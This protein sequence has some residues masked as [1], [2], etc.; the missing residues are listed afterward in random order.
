MARYSEH[1]RSLIDQAVTEWSTR[2]LVGDGSLLFPEQLDVW[3]E[4]SAADLYQRFNMSGLTDKRTFM[5]KWAAQLDGASRQVRLFAAELLLVHFLFASSVSGQAKRAIVQETL[6]GSDFALDQDSVGIRALGQA[7]GHPGIGFNVGRDRQ[8]A[9]LIDFTRRLKLRPPEERAEILRDPWRL[10]DFA[11][12]T[13][14]SVREMRHILLHL[15]RPDEFERISSGTHKREIAAAF[16][17]LLGED[18]PQ[19]LDERLLAIRRRLDELMPAGNTQKGLIDFYHPP[20]WGV[21]ES[22]GG[23]DDDGTGDLEALLWKKQIVLY[24]PPGTSKSYQARRLAETLIRRVALDRWKPEGFFTHQQ[25][26]EDVIDRCVRWIQLH[27]GY[28][29][30]EFIRGLRLDGSETRYQPGALPALIDDMAQQRPPDGLP[31][32]PFV[33]VLDEINR[34]DLSALFGEAFSLIERDRRG[35]PGAE[36]PGLNVGDPPARLVVPEDLYIIGTMNEID[37]SVETLDF[38]LRRRFLWRECP[39]ERDTLL[40]IISSRWHDDVGKKWHHE[41]AMP[42]L[43][44]FADRAAALN[45]AIDDSEELGRAYA[46]GHTYFADLTFFLGTWLAGRKSAPPNG[47]F[48]WTGRNRAQPPLVDLWERSLRP[49]LEQYLAGSDAGADE[50]RRLRSIFFDTDGRTG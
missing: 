13:D 43:E 33:L 50:L 41:S 8:V 42:Q 16:S 39:F 34:T 47:T 30:E 15:L 37:Q 6:A 4:Q 23:G 45:D 32:L 1:D 19:D 44:R 46:I 49:L 2:C 18:A 25:A 28:G 22:A 36:L 17:G 48:L 29:Y 38:A 40:S 3:T 21:W 31:S 7:I 20:L 27:P 10:R 5:Q 14:E 11:D 9:Y 35:E 12:D 26:L 24:G